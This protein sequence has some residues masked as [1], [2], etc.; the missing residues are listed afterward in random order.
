MLGTERPAARFPRAG[1]DPVRHGQRSASP[2]RA[3]DARRSG[4]VCVRACMRACVRACVH[5]CDTPPL[6]LSPQL[7]YPML[8]YGGAR[9]RS[10]DLFGDD[11][12]VAVTKRFFKVRKHV[13]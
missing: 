4:S 12:P 2:V 13:W 8:D 7:V 1:H 9:A 3:Y 5:V 6:P 10:S 11:D